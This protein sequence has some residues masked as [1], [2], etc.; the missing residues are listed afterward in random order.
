VFSVEH[1]RQ[2]RKTFLQVVEENREERAKH[3]VP[4]MKALDSEEFQEQCSHV[5]RDRNRKA[6]ESELEAMKLVITD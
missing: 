4:I 5:I 1:Y 3:M 6:V 2:R